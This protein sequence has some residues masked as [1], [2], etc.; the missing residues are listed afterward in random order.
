MLTQECRSA[1]Q[2]RACPLEQLSTPLHTSRGISLWQ[3]LKLFS[4]NSTRQDDMFLSN[5]KILQRHPRKSTD[6]SSFILYIHIIPKNCQE[7]NGVSMYKLRVFDSGFPKTTVVPMDQLMSIPPDLVF[8]HRKM[9]Q[10][11]SCGSRFGRPSWLWHVAPKGS[12]TIR[13]GWS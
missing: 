8:T 12:T 11:I 4:G 6:F 9:W 10:H 2:G 7:K 13:E 3:P 5:S 1:V